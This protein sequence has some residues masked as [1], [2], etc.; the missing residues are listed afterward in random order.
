MNS[1]TIL[2]SAVALGLAACS[3]GGTDD[4]ANNSSTTESDAVVINQAVAADQTVPANGATPSP[5]Q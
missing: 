3:G 2:A 5:K 1:R 4:P